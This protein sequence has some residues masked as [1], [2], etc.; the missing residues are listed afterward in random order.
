M[1]DLIQ[2]KVLEANYREDNDEQHYAVCRS[3]SIIKV[4]ERRLVYI[5]HNPWS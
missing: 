1:R 3:H 2:S 5:I 4:A